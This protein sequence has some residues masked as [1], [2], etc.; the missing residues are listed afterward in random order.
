MDNKIQKQMILTEN[1]WKVVLKLSIPAI[2]AM[3]LYGLNSVFDAIFVG[4]YVGQAALA[5]VSI[6][7]PLSQ[8]TLG[9][10]SLIGVG[11]GSLLSIV[12]GNNN[13]DVQNKILG[14]VNYLTIVTTFVYA[15]LAYIFSENLV[16]VMGGKGTILTMGIEY[17]KITIIGSVFWIHGLALNMIVRAEGKMKSAALMM[18][19]GLFVN[20][21]ANYIFIVLLD[22]GVSGAAWGTNIGMFV[23]TLLGLYYFKSNRA[24]FVAKPLS[25]QLDKDVSKSIFSMGMASLIMQF[26]NLVMAVVVF[27]ALSNYGTEFDLAFYGAS[28]RIFTFMLTPLFG[29]M[30]ALQPTVGINYGAGNYERVISSMKR[31]IAVGTIVVIPFWLFLLIFPSTILSLMLPNTVFT[32]QML[33]HFRVLI[34]LLPLLPTIFMAM[35]FFPAIDKG[36]I[37]SVL[38]LLRQLVLYVPVMLILPKY[39]GIQWVYYGITL[40]DSVIGIAFIV[41]VI[42]E[43]KKLKQQ[44]KEP[45]PITN[46]GMNFNKFHQNAKIN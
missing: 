22:Y 28:Y 17:F 4:R 25:L 20:I 44:N 10:G 7:Y 26:M 3:V 9:I 24:T 13:T 38:G 6:A 11:A 39:F 27:N 32:S 45:E 1:L 14:N 43:F 29:L 21:I 8:M 23:Y 15:V 33:L 34:L 16:A 42:L 5:G 31:F 36:K 37:A 35:T 19:I 40:I 41:F 2:I 12:L 30:R 18:G 46:Q